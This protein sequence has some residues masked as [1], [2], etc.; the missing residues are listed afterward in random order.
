MDTPLDPHP[1]PSPSQA[2]SSLL[3]RIRVL[4]LGGAGCNFA[5][6]MHR[7]RFEGVEYFAA[8]T[9]LQSLSASPVEHKIQL[10]SRMAR[11]LGAGGDPEM[12]RACAEADTER[13][14][15]ACE[16]ADIVF[17]LAGLGGG[18]GTGAAPVAARIAKECGAIALAITTLPWEAEG[19]RRMQ[20]AQAGLRELQAAADAVITLPNEKLAALVEEH[21]NLPDSF[22]RIND[23]LTQGLRGVWQMLALRGIINIDFAD[24]RAV[25][26]GRHAESLVATSEAAGSQRAQD[27]VDKLLGSPFLDGGDA[28]RQ[29]DMMLLSIL[30]GSDLQLGEVHRLMELIQRL[31]PEAHLIVGAAVD[32][33]FTGK[34]T[35][36]VLASRK[37]APVEVS[38][39]AQ[40][41]AP[42]PPTES[43]TGFMRPQGQ[44]KSGPT[45]L[46]PPPPEMSF[47]K[48]QQLFAK[49]SPGRRTR[50]SGK[51]FEQVMLPLDVVSKGRFEKSVPNIRDGED[52]DYPTYIRRGMQLN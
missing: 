31:S 15:A 2:S 50:V 37:P 45:K 23:V 49:Q 21:T 17:L 3:V 40:A 14:R 41:P 4:G 38:K 32:P 51:K 39:P 16:G 1:I 52:L 24:L 9:D 19:P 43:D 29:C 25:L 42:L 30:G 44:V 28:L 33:S 20:Q 7:T 5:N 46:V 47:E 8:N 18:T 48:K 13:L 12:G 10:G 36:T 27:C 35:V 11:G 6:H 26:G 34:L 22:E